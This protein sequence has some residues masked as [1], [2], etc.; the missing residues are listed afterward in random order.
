MEQ[1]K[2]NFSSN[3]NISVKSFLLFGH[4]SLEMNV[5]SLLVLFSLVFVAAE[6]VK[7]EEEIIKEEFEHDGSSDNDIDRDL[8]N[9]LID[10]D[11]SDEDSYEIDSE[12]EDDV[13]MDGRTRL[14]I[15]KPSG[16]CGY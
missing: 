5:K 11:D 10:I 6:F 3:F 2:Y 9:E 14:R 8:I 15:M 12:E 4:F 16:M 13:K 7:C 1:L